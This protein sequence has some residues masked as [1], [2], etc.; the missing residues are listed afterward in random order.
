MV[1]IEV[2]RIFTRNTTTKRTLLE[3]ADMII[4]LESST[5]TLPKNTIK[6]GAPMSNRGKSNHVTV[7][8]ETIALK[9]SILRKITYK[10]DHLPKEKE[11]LP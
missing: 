7:T 2:K 1:N 11:T 6:K 8:E 4:L 10:I 3:K 9:T 5:V